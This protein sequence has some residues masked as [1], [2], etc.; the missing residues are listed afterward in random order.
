MLVATQTVGYLSPVLSAAVRGRRS[1]RPPANPLQAAVPRR[2]RSDR[3]RLGTS[4]RYR[5]G[6]DHSRGVASRIL[7]ALARSPRRSGRGRSRSRGCGVSRGRFPCGWCPQRG[8]RLFA[9]RSSCSSGL[10]CSSEWRRRVCACRCLRLFG[11]RRVPFPACSSSAASSPARRRGASPSHSVSRREGPIVQPA[12]VAVA[13]WARR[14]L[15]PGQRV[16]AEEADARLLLVYAISTFSPGRTRPSRLVLE[17]PVPLP[18]AARGV[19][20]EPHP[21]CRHRRPPSQRRRQHGL[22]LRAAPRGRRRPLPE[23]RSDEV[24]ASR[25]PPHLRQRGDHRRRHCGG[26]VCSSYAVARRRRSWPRAAGWSSHSFR[27]CHS[28]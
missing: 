25:R 16:A 13:R 11:W 28:V 14:V 7:R 5:V 1:R 3:A 23:N 24:R 20:A 21:L 12:G 26:E 8:R 17:T 9:H 15:G 19:A 10:R 22:L 4:R 2:W 6:A 27:V 18:L